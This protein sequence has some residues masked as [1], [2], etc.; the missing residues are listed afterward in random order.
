MA[1]T[2]GLWLSRPCKTDLKILNLSEDGSLEILGRT[3][4]HQQLTAPALEHHVMLVLEAI[5]PRFEALQTGK[6]LPPVAITPVS[7]FTSLVQGSIAVVMAF[8][9][10]NR[11]LYK[12]ALSPLSDYVF[13]LAQ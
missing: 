9:V 6:T 10:A 5:M 11:V 8:G 1:L 4:I 7:S 3:Y 2:V 13:F 12:M